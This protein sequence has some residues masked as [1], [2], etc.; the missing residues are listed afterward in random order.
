MYITVASRER[1]ETA[2][3]MWLSRRW[4]FFVTLITALIIHLPI[5]DAKEND[6][7]SPPIRQGLVSSIDQFV[8]GYVD[9]R[10]FSGTILVAQGDT[11]LVNEGYGMSVYEHAV[12][13]SKNTKYLIGSVSK[14]FTAAAILLLQERNEL[15]LDDH[16]SRFIPEYPRGHDITVRH[17]LNHTSGL[18]RLVFFPDFGERSQRR[19]A[20]RDLVEWFQNQPLVNLPGEKYSY[21]N[22]NYALLAHIIEEVSETTYSDFLNSNILESLNLSNT[23]HRGNVSKIIENLAFG[24][25]PVGLVELERSRN[26]DYSIFTGSGSLYSTTS[27]L[28][29]WFR[30]RQRGQLL[31]PDTRDQMLQDGDSPWDF[32]WIPEKRLNRD[33]LVMSGWDGVGFSAHFVHYLAED[34]T[35]IVLANLNMSSIA[36]EI[37]DNLSAI[38][39]EEKFAPFEVLQRPTVD[40]EMLLDMAGQYRFGSDFYVPNTTIRIAESN[41]QLII[42]ANEFGPEGGLLPVSDGVF[43]HRQQWFTVTF[44]KS[45]DGAV[46]GIVYGNFK[47][48]KERD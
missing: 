41:G 19:H 35:V 28:F 17:L 8:N 1:L 6:G 43:V 7:E 15:E 29:R 25:T 24:Y 16:I 4:A 39:F 27:D 13:N 48:A 26:F 10:N 11:I 44:E 21:S 18:P 30:A 42:P 47:A 5:A 12:P 34:V 3:D 31:K 38:V 22:A 9:G 37:S 14:S 36:S 32:G 23:G 45:T 20:T 2:S 33:A 40:R 46:T